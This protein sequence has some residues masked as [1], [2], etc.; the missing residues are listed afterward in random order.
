[1]LADIWTEL[2]LSLGLSALSPI[3]P[4]VLFES[5]D[6]YRLSTPPDCRRR[7]ARC[8]RDVDRQVEAAS[9]GSQPVRG[10]CATQMDEGRMS[11]SQQ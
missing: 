7:P 9:S 3:S 11:P 1:M 5:T 10:E 4:P 8:Q 2:R 6:L